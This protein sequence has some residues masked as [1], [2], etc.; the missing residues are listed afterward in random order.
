MDK[1]T[2]TDREWLD[3]LGELAFRVTR[4]HATERAYS[5]EGF[6]EGPGT[7]VCACCGA[8]LFDASTKFESHCG[9][10]SFYADKSNGLVG[11][12]VDRSHFMVRTEVHCNRCD[13]HLG[14]VFPDGPPPT[15]LRY[16]I[17]GVA[18]KFVPEVAT[19]PD[20]S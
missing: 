17:N 5:H 2:K 11:E 8:P 19:A 18:L 1:V 9:W 15:G 10:P 4:K 3:Q 13:A 12:E 20:P 7:Y 6:P 16:C 14:H